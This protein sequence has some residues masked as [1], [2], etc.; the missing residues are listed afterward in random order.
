MNAR[1][2]PL[3]MRK[4]SG[5]SPASSVHVVGERRTTYPRVRILRVLR[6][7]CLVLSGVA[8]VLGGVLF[9]RAAYAIVKGLT[10]SQSL[11]PPSTPSPPC[12][13]E[14]ARLTLREGVVSIT[15]TDAT[16][17]GDRGVLCLAGRRVVLIRW[18]G[19]AK[20]LAANHVGYLGVRRS[21]GLSRPWAVRAATMGGAPAI[22]LSDTMRQRVY[23]DR[24]DGSALFAYILRR[25]SAVAAEVGDLD[26][27]GD[28][29]VLVAESQGGH[30]ACLGHD[31][32]L[33]WG[34]TPTDWDGAL[35]L[36]CADIEGNGQP[37]VVVQMI[38][39]GA[40]VLGADGQQVGS[41]S[42][43]RHRSAVIGGRAG[44]ARRASL[45]VV[46]VDGFVPGSRPGAL[47]LVGQTPDG[48]V[49]WATSVGFGP[50]TRIRERM[51]CGD[52]NGDGE[53]EW[54]FGAPDGTVRVLDGGGHELARRAM[55]AHITALNTTPPGE[56]ADKAH[57]WVAT[58]RVVT[59]L[60]WQRP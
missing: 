53:R 16:W 17:P 33:E 12:L 49:L 9:L 30:V 1:G 2:L 48:G 38:R 7:G 25:A 51:A 32:K 22:V 46:G 36:A 14:T 37:Q 34:F 6:S 35:A 39:S 11:A 55:G 3:P 58:G 29:E 27:D 19:A 50:D 4:P 60:E 57:V 43:P 44:S 21:D 10:F 23:V 5:G 13:A 52:V 31:G 8:V 20:A 41:L 24:P 59:A 18:G 28:D 26:G 40:L 47:A 54:V 15:P 42:D 45:L 56:G